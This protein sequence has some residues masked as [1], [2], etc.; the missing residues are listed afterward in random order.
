MV[1][2]KK[3]SPKTYEK[4]IPEPPIEDVNDLFTV[5]Q[6]GNITPRSNIKLPDLSFLKV[7]IFHFRRLHTG[8]S[9]IG[10]KKKDPVRKFL[11]QD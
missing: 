6:Q 10:K 2:I 1:I 5:D 8:Q 9:L 7:G 4:V 11:L 3:V